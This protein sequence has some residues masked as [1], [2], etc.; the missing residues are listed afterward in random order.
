M[1]WLKKSCGLFCGKSCFTKCN[2]IL[3]FLILILCA[4]L[5]LSVYFLPMLNFCKVCVFEE[6]RYDESGRFVFLLSIIKLGTSSDFTVFPLSYLYV[7]FVKF[8]QAYNVHTCIHV[9][10]HGVQRRMV[11]VVIF[12]YFRYHYVLLS[13]C[14]M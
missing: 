14:Y 7:L 11:S 1:V 2:K 12:S 9:S 4:H 13:C 3:S 10:N 5:L 8:C 6:K